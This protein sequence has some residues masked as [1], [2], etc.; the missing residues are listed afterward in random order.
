MGASVA[1][2]IERRF[3]RSPALPRSPRPR[4]SASPSIV[5]QFDLNRN[6]DGAA[7]DVQTALTVAARKLPIE[8]MIPP[9]FRKVNPADQPIIKLQPRL[10][11]AASCRRSTTMARSRWRSRYRSCRASL[12]FWCSARRNSPFASRS[13]RSPRHPAASRWKTCAPCL[14]RPIRT[15]RSAPSP[16]SRQAE[17]HP[18][19][20]GG[21]A[22]CRRIPQRHRRLPQWPSRSGSAKSPTSSMTSK[23]SSTPIYYKNEK[24]IVLAVYKQSSGNTVKIVDAIYDQLPR[25]R[26][27]IPPSVKMELFADR[28]V[29]IR[30]FGRRRAGD[31]GDRHRTGR[32]W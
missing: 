29:S 5:I 6:I 23:T 14:P 15:R 4:R 13:I 27:Q 19:R 22:H 1:G 2:P 32:G 16:G 31:A 21:D 3:R 24:S 20:T 26:A 10:V 7:L 17:H 30:D 25:Y 8:M 9:S 18:R 11:D 28:S 12:R